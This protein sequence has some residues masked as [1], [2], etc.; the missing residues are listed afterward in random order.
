MLTQGVSKIFR[1]IL[2][3]SKSR[4]AIFVFTKWSSMLFYT[5]GQ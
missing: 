1:D 5:P 3:V 4:Y 2:L